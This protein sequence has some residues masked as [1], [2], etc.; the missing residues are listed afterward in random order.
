[1]YNSYGA[2]PAAHRNLLAAADRKSTGLAGLIA[3]GEETT[4]LQGLVTQLSKANA[5]AANAA[6]N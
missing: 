1:M 5:A 6:S 2:L 3:L 4:R